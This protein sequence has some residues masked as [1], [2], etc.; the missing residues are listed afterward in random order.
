MMPK[1]PKCGNDLLSTGSGPGWMN[2]E[3]WDSVKAGDYFCENSVHGLV[4]FRERDLVK[5]EPHHNHD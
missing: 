2:E 4:Y 1:C 5:V 3:Q